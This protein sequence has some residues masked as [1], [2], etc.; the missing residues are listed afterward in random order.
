[1]GRDIIYLDNSA[2][3]WPKPRR[4]AK[5]M[6]NAISEFGANPGRG[7]YRLTR[8]TA[9]LVE[10]AREVTADFFGMNDPQRVIFTAGATASLNMALLGTLEKGDVLL[11]TGM[12]HNAVSRPAAALADHRGVI[13]RN[14]VADSKGGI[15]GKQVIRALKDRPRPRL[16]V[17]DHGSNVCG[18]VADV[19]ALAPAARRARVPL[20]LDAAQTA[21]LLPVDM[22]RMSLA[23]CAIAGHKALYGPAGIGVLLLSPK[24][25]PAP[26]IYGGTGSRSEERRQPESY[27]EHLEAGSVNVPGIA[28]FLA[29]LEFVREIGRE[30]L[31][32][33]SLSLTKR[34]AEGLGNIRGIRLYLPEGGV[35]LPVLSV[36]VRGRD[37]A[38]V[39]ALLDR[40][41]GICVRSGYH[42]APAAHRAL[43][44]LDAGT[45]RFSPGWFNTPADIDA[46]ISAMKEIAGE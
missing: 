42:C 6:A 1:M 24:L 33:K 40:R 34:L 16:M 35:A 18:A 8:H 29:G 23:A 36:N 5:A 37:P 32:E 46:A 22:R 38:T 39:A 27:P 43:G 14:L 20:L 26:L 41:Y 4:V 44:T 11:L 3:S 12:E 10:A 28:G 30:R 15:D 17:V 21:G 45:V 7:N 13:L 9:A 25:H 31:L 2:G 19:A